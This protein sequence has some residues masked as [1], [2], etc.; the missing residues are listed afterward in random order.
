MKTIDADKMLSEVNDVTEDIAKTLELD[1]GK[2]I[3]LGLLLDKW[4]ESQP[5][6]G[7][8]IS[9][10]VDGFTAKLSIIINYL[11]QKTGTR[12]R[13]STKKTQMCVRA[14]LAEGFDVD[15]F[16]TVID[17]KVEQWGNDE[18]MSEYLRPETLFGTKFESYL[19]NA[20]RGHG[21]N[22]RTS[23]RRDSTWQ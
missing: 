14:R 17:S 13:A 22:E 4:V 19:Q 11:N 5:K 21:T 16:K 6:C 20:T 1:I 2:K 12:Y 8:G 18:R 9:V 7:N 15:D 10:S 3:A 23:S